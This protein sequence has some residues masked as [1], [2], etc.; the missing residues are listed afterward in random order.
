MLITGYINNPES[1]LQPLKG[2]A[3]VENGSV[4]GLSSNLL[5]KVLINHASVLRSVKIINIKISSSVVEDEIPNLVILKKDFGSILN[6][7]G[8]TFYF[9]TKLP[10]SVYDYTNFTCEVI[11]HF[12]EEDLAVVQLRLNQG[13]D[14]IDT[15]SPTIIYEGYKISGKGDTLICYVV[16]TDMTTMVIEKSSSTGLWINRSTLVYS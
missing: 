12:N 2:V 1:I 8:N 6:K 14:L 7:T 16:K 3:T 5:V 15:T 11:Y 13:P 9:D 10:E 4:S